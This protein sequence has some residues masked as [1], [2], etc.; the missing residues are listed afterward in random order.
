MTI[1][2]LEEQAAN[3]TIVDPTGVPDLLQ[4]ESYVQATLST[5]DTPGLRP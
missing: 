5:L 4:T 1:A 2:G 3:P